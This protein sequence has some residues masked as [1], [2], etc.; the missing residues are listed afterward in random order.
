MKRVRDHLLQGEGRR[1]LVRLQAS[2]R[3]TEGIRGHGCGHPA[4]PPGADGRLPGLLAQE[5]VL[6]GRGRADA[7][8]GTIER[9]ERNEE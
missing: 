1:E 9:I 6:P 4:L 5:A 8:Q 3:I 2:V 7:L